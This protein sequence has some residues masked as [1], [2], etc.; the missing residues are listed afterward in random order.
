MRAKE[1]GAKLIVVDPRA[2]PL[3]RFAD[4]HLRQRPGTDVAWINGFIN[5]IINEG[6]PANARASWN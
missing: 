5:V 3:T 6:K 1:K 4:F 2:I